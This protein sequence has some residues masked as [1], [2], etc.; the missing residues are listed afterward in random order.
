MQTILQSIYIIYWLTLPNFH[1]I[2]YFLGVSM[3]NKKRSRKNTTTKKHAMQNFVLFTTVII[4]LVLLI[5]AIYY[6]FFPSANNARKVVPNL[7]LND[8]NTVIQNASYTPVEVDELTNFSSILKDEGYLLA[9]VSA[10]NFS[11]VLNNTPPTITSTAFLMSNSFV[12][13]E[14]VE[15]LLFSNNANQSIRGY[16]YNDTIKSYY[17]YYNISIPFYTVFSVAVFNNSIISNTEKSN[18][19]FTMPVFQYTTIFSYSDYVGVVVVN[20]YSYSNVYQNYSIKLAELLAR[21]LI[22]Y[23]INNS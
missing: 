9:S 6:T 8:I 21:K 17:S 4:V 2:I 19:S 15:S 7:T 20:S 22:A 1:K 23:S 12:A 5:S 11:G 16:V 14:T 10:F 13:N 18:G 3:V